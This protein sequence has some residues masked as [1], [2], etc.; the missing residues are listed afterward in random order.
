MIQSSNRVSRA[1]VLHWHNATVSQM[2]REI[3]SENAGAAIGEEAEDTCHCV[4]WSMS[5]YA[6]EFCGN[7]FFSRRS[8]TLKS[9]HHK[10]Y[11]ESLHWSKHQHGQAHTVALSQIYCAC[12]SFYTAF[13]RSN[14]IT[15]IT[16][17]WD[18]MLVSLNK[19]VSRSKMPNRWA[20]KVF[21]CRCGAF[22]NA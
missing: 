18:Q 19:L 2:F 17:S 14:Q 8:W 7:A 4:T 13:G 6:T 15:K 20:W 9:C 16:K 21:K 12:L 1:S 22:D 3:L 10:L 5:W 11:D